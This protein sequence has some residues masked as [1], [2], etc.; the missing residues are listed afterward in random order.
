MMENRK[1]LENCNILITS[2][3]LH[4]HKLINSFMHRNFAG[5]AA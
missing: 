3:D 2:H 4:L 5:E 1:N